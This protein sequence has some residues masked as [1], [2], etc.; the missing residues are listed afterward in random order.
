MRRPGVDLGCFV[1]CSSPVLLV[2]ARPWPWP[3]CPGS[4]SDRAAGLALTRRTRPRPSS[5][6]EDGSASEVYTS[7]WLYRPPQLRSVHGPRPA[8]TLA[9]P[10]DGDVR[11]PRM[12]H[13]ASDGAQKSGLSALG[14]SAA[15][16]DQPDRRWPL[17]R[18]LRES[19]RAL[20][21]DHP[22][23]RV[24]CSTSRGW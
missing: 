21:I 11:I 13:A 23:G 2:A 17:C 8:A 19:S 16:G 24:R 20:A 5:S 1:P 14:R 12:S 22:I 15:A 9:G 10:I 4:R 7:R 18:R 3:P 6:E